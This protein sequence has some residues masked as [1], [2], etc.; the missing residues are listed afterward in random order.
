MAFKTTV[1]SF[2][3]P[4]IRF[5][6]PT[7]LSFS[8]CTHAYAKCPPVLYIQDFSVVTVQLIRLKESTKLRIRYSNP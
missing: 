1:P 3:F 6:A 5:D 2:R 7:Q 8:G 4:A